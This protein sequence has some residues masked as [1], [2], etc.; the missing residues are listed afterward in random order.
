LN[1][2]TLVMG[3]MGL[4]LI[5]NALVGFVT[6]Q[7]STPMVTG[8]QLHCVLKIDFDIVRGNPTSATNVRVDVI[9]S[10]MKMNSIAL[11]IPSIHIDRMPRSG[12]II[13]WG[14]FIFNM[15]MPD[16][17]TMVCD[18]KFMLSFPLLHEIHLGKGIFVYNDQMHLGYF[19]GSL[20]NGNDGSYH[21][22]GIL[23]VFMKQ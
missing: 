9:W 5:P 21:V 10:Q 22:T 7:T 1:V 12:T 13:I 16:T 18:G 20:E 23:Y 11:T 15:Q 8:W 19:F 14:T 6:A 2:K 17:T 3:L 4:I